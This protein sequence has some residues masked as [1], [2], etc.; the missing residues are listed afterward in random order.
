MSQVTETKE[1]ALIRREVGGLME[2]A[3][4]IVVINDG[5]AR[6]A[7]DLLVFIAEAKKKLEAQR[8]FLVKPL[9]DHVKNINTA[10]KEWTKPLETADSMVRR[11]VL[12]FQR[13]QEA[14]R[15][16]LERRE[17][18]RLEAEAESLALLNP[19]EE[20]EDLPDLPVLPPPSR[21]IEGDRGS[22]SV[23]KT[24]AYEVTSERDVPRE[25]LVIDEGA[26]LLAVRKGARDIPGVRIYQQD[27]LSV[28]AR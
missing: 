19:D 13:E 14:D 15:L 2:T 10:F 9:N 8:V 3:R 16:E 21:K 24:W 7:N 22:T 4:E 20:P 11:K 18:E 27:S 6:S 1:L 25:Y 17:R 23:R 28:R 12:T 5:S 26:I